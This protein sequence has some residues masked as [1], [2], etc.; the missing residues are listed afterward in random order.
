MKT[1]IPEPQAYYATPG[2]MTGPGPYAHLF[3]GLPADLPSLVKIVQNSILHVFWAERYGVT[4]PE[5]RKATLQ[6]RPVEKK[7]D[8]WMAE[9]GGR[10]ETPRP[11]E[12]RQVGNCRDFSLLLVSI[13]RHQGR[14]ARARCG[15]GAYFMP[16]HFEDHWVVEV[17]ESGEN[18]WRMVDAQLDAL[19]QERLGID[20]DPLDMPPGRFVPAGEAWRMARSGEQDPEKFGIFEIHGMEFIRGNLVREVL[21]LNKVEILP[22]DWFIGYLTEE[23]TRPEKIEETYAMFD[24]IAA[25]T[26]AGDECFAELRTL[27]QNDPNWQIPESWT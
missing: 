6:I 16:D 8:C 25:L 5:E 18:R 22:W 23:A 1:T 14:P 24:R 27:Y 26:L 4:L 15:F 10:L 13:L 9:Q 3:D 7:L 19:Q 20:F 17:W 12:K 11:P 2:V 21:S